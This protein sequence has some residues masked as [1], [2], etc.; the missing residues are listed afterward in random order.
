M[1]CSCVAWPRRTAAAPEGDTTRDTVY[2]RELK[3]YA[4]NGACKRAVPD[5]DM[6]SCSSDVA[7]S[8]HC[9]GLFQPSADVS[10]SLHVR[11]T[12]A[13]G[14]TRVARLPLAAISGVDELQGLFKALVTGAF[15]GAL[16]DYLTSP[17]Y[18]Q[19]APVEDFV[20]L[21][22]DAA[23]VTRFRLV[24]SFG[25]WDLTLAERSMGADP[26]PVRRLLVTMAEFDSEPVALE[27]GR[28]LIVSLVAYPTVS[29]HRQFLD[30]AMRQL[31][32][33]A[34]EGGDLEV[35][36][37]EDALPEATDEGDSAGSTLT[38]L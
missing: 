37:A 22:G 24:A 14:V 1:L 4:T 27:D 21:P 17:D 33:E 18:Y 35:N 15:P 12:S 7:C 23:A 9:S 10:L 29:V 36:G 11:R 6:L 31:L 32:V 19:F 20:S 5:A 25:G 16:P 8:K 38:A 3:A 13:E 28:Q 26:D 34:G 2:M 30:G